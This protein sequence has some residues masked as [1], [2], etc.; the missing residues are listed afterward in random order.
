M[1]EWIQDAERY[2]MNT[3]ARSPVVLVKGRGSRVYDADGKEYI[4]FVAGVAVNSLGYCD[5]RV[6]VAFQKQAQRLV[7]VSNLYYN[8]PQI[9]LAKLLVRNSFADKVFFCNSGAE[10]NEA[11]FKLAR[12]FADDR[13]EK[14][15]RAIITMKGSFHG[16]TLATLS[17]TGQE[18]IHKGFE[19]L[20]PGFIH[21]PYDN[22]DAVRNAVTNR[23]IA[24]MVEPILGEGGVIIPSNEFLPGLRKLCDEKGLLLI[25]DEVQ[26]GLGRTGKLF[27]YEHAGVTPDIMTLAKG[28]GGGM[29]IG[30]MLAKDAVAKH[31]TPGSH[32]STFGGGPLACAAAMA[33]MNAILED[34]IVLDNVTRMGE[35]LM[36]GLREIRDEFSFVKD[37]R[38]RGLLIGIEFDFNARPLVKDLLEEGF[39]VNVPTE[40]TM[41]LVPPL[42]I[43]AKE[44]DLL[45]DALR[46]VLKRRP[47]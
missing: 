26:T 10:A 31:L 21:V 32:A 33:T 14:D 34:G 30:A 20:V 41:R 2:V 42:V 29:P 47:S 17:A 27:A 39:L 28:L 12:K 19:P 9:Q 24:V 4:D 44:I 45:L 16:R 8:E 43:G 18:K 5:H 11:A 13:G 1:E 36:A 38:G 23:T 7:H 3:Y 15:G 46:R 37:V 6:T 35:R 22:L 25:L 40:R